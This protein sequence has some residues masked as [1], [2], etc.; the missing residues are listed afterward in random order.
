MC[1]ETEKTPAALW[2][3]RYQKS[4][5]AAP[6]PE[7]THFKV[8]ATARGIVFELSICT[9]HTSVHPFLVTAIA[10][11]SFKGFFYSLVEMSTWIQ[12]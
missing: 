1:Q 9:V 3:L 2:T 4:L 11:E 6:I 8:S 12:R 7:H 5:S 10:Q